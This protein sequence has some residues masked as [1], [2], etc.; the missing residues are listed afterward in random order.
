MAHGEHGQG[1]HASGQCIGHSHDLEEPLLA[2]G[3]SAEEQRRLKNA[4]FFALFMMFAEIVG[5]VF[6]NSLAIITDAAHMLSDV[7][8]FIVS[9]FCL[10]LAARGMTSEYTYGFKQAEVLGAML[11][12]SIVWAL[13]ACVLMEAVK[14]FYS[15]EEIKAPYMFWISV[16]GVI[17]NLILMKVL[18]HGH[19]H[20]GEGG[21]HG[22]SHGGHGGHGG[23]GEEDDEEQA[24]LAMKAALAHVI[25]DV[26]QSVSVCIAAALIWW[27][28][29]DV[30]VTANGVSKWNYADPIC[31]IIFGILV[32]FTTVPT[33]KQAINVLMAK[34]PSQ[35][36][37]GAFTNKLMAVNGVASIH[38]LHLWTMGSNDVLCSAH[39]QVK[40]RDDVTPV[41]KDA[42]K[43]AQSLGISHSTFQIEIEGEFDP[44]LETYGIH[45][46]PLRSP[47]NAHG[48]HGCGHGGHGGGAGHSH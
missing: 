29:Y 6:A 42:I 45:D 10:Q 15:L 20:G 27:Q 17:V 16:L 13:T 28:P 4:V 8:G 24:S 9:L 31:S 23:H 30:G 21:G 38:D 39:I 3:N 25:G 19:S 34:V 5:G 46:N 18:G 12:I 48:K 11:S 44:K 36:N 22:H 40:G 35:V 32:L 14:R 2:G 41:L 43:V 26:V 7:G 33:M 47:N 1:G 37:G